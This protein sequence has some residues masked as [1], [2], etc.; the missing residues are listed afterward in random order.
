[1]RAQHPGERLREALID[2]HRR[3]EG[4]SPGSNVDSFTYKR[5]LRLPSQESLGFVDDEQIRSLRR[6]KRVAA[7]RENCRSGRASVRV[8]G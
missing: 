8:F 5:D 4:F 3:R 1:V 7:R 6:A 2:G